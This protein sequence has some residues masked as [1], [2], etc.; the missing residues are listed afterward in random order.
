MSET[1]KETFSSFVK[2]ELA[3]LPFSHIQKKALLAGFVRNSGTLRST[4][5]GDL[6][7]LSTDYSLVAELLYRALTELFHASCRYS[8]VSSS[9]ERGSLRFHV[10]VSRP[11]RIYEELDIQTSPNKIPSFVFVDENLAPAYVA[12][13]FLGCGY[14]NDPKTTNYHLEFSFAEESYANRFLKMLNKVNG[15]NF[16]FKSIKRRKQT[17]VYLKRSEKIS[18]FLSFMGA[19]ESCLSF[20][21]IR[22]DRDF[23]NI[24]NRLLNLDKANDSK[25]SQAS[26]KQIHEIEALEAIGAFEELD[27]PKIGI[28][29]ALRLENPDASMDALSEMMTEEMGMSVSKSNVNH[30]FRAIHALYFERIGSD[31]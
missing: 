31:E 18:E 9:G 13:A 29:C 20:E 19:S 5:E 25:K 14:V 21:N 16:L 27:N 24:G 1:T 22:I 7:D 8:C 4:K 17:I 30:L 11:E 10:I 23:A 6:L 15:G 12:G 3:A 2:C 28:L 26:A